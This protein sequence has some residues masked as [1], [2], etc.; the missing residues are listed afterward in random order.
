MAIKSTKKINLDFE[1]TDLPDRYCSDKAEPLVCFI[2][3]HIDFLPYICDALTK[4]YGFNSIN[5][6]GRRNKNKFKVFVQTIDFENEDN[7]KYVQQFENLFR[8]TY[9][10]KSDYPGLNDEAIQKKL[11]KV[12]GR[13]L[14]R[15]IESF[16]KPKYPCLKSNPYMNKFSTGCMVFIN[17]KQ[18]VIKDRISVDIA[19][20]NGLIGEFYE[21]K[22]GPHK[23]DESVLSL[24]SLI[25]SE[26]DNHNI[27]SVVGCV[28]MANK[29]K[30]MESIEEIK[31]SINFNEGIKIFGKHELITLKDNQFELLA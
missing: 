2:L 7:Y 23:F 29:Y 27:T 14:E 3:E 16:V 12:R 26:M 22:V 1:V 20:W 13:I 15:I 9:D 8:Q 5:E 18:L 30:L 24:L 28:T 25:K 11:S 6:L 21:T 17:N 10:I 19:A 4:F 31:G